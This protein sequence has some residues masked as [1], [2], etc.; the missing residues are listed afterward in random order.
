M[1]LFDQ[2]S[3]VGPLVVVMS[4]SDI[5]AGDAT[6]TLTLLKSLLTDVSCMKFRQCVV[7]G[8]HGYDDDRRELFEIPEVRTFM[9]NLDAEWPYW[10]FFAETESRSTIPLI[11]FSLCP[12]QAVGPQQ[13]MLDS[14]YL[15]QF[16]EVRFSAMNAL[17]D[18]LGDTEDEIL[19][20]TENIMTQF[21]AT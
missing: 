3:E 9:A 18:W 7:F 12:F 11:V 16:L 21:G 19:R 10:F 14:Q 17:C 5:E 6:E 20:M 13:K 15:G 1:N 2:E 4:R 8:I